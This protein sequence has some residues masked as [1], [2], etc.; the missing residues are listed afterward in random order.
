MVDNIRLI[1]IKKFAFQL[2]PPNLMQ[3]RHVKCQ[4][5]NKLEQEQLL[6][7]K[8]NTLLFLE[9]IPRTDP[10]SNNTPP[11]QSTKKEG[12]PILFILSSVNLNCKN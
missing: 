7:I 3:L 6:I 1:L 8:V 11:I 10:P 2:L 12:H 5:G 9:C 4:L